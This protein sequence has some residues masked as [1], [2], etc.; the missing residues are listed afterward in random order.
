MYVY[1]YRYTL[2]MYTYIYM[3]VY[4]DV[5]IYIYIHTYIY[6]HDICTNMYEKVESKKRES[7]LAAMDACSK[8]VTNFVIV[9]VREPSLKF[10]GQFGVPHLFGN[11]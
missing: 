7:V 3:Y 6:I 5:Y 8:D 10:K 4:M 11:V 2:H 1:I 9:L